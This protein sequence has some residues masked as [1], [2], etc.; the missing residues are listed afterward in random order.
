MGLKNQIIDAQTKK[1]LNDTG[2]FF[3]DAFIVQSAWSLENQRPE[4]MFSYL[5]NLN[6]E[7]KIMKNDY[8]PMMTAQ[9]DAW[10]AIA[11]KYLNKN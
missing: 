3:R 5:N 8:I 2:N 7:I 1:S 11:D 6:E 4:R 9:T 10:E